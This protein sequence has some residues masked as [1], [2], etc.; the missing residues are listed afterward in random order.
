MFKCKLIKISRPDDAI[1]TGLRTDTVEGETYAKPEVGKCFEMT[2]ESLTTPGIGWR[3]VNTSPIVNMTLIHGVK[4]GYE[5][6]TMSG[7]VYQIIIL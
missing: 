6:K 1:G 4:D 7:S 5:V 3:N 2:G